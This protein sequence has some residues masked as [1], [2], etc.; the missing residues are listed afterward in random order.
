MEIIVQIKL[1]SLVYFEDSDPWIQ[2]ESLVQ[3]ANYRS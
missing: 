3:K 2:I 1:N